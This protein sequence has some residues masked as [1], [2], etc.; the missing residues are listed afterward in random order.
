MKMWG[1]NWRSKN[2]CRYRVVSASHYS[3]NV[4]TPT[5]VYGTTYAK[6]VATMLSKVTRLLTPASISFYLS[7]A[8]FNKGWI[9]EV[10][11]YRKMWGVE[12][13]K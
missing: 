1:L 12:L 3:G 13:A 6:L 2:L 4:H 9:R 11:K 10:E 5:P 7:Q 8:R